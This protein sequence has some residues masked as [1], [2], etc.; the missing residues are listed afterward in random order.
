MSVAE[1]SLTDE[2]LRAG[3]ASSHRGRCD[4]AAA[5]ARRHPVPDGRQAV[6][7]GPLD[8]NSIL[9]G[10]ETMIRREIGDGVD[11][12][13]CLAADL[14]AA[15]AD[16]AQ[17]EQV[18]LNLSANARDAMPEGG[19]LTIET[20]NAEV[21]EKSAFWHERVAPGQYVML[22][23]SDTG[24][25]MDATT[26]SRLFEPFFPAKTP[27]EGASL[28]LCIVHG[29][30]SRNGGHIWLYSEPGHGTILRIY[31]PRADGRVGSP[32]SPDEPVVLLRGT[33]T[34]LLAEDEPSIRAEVLEALA[35]QGY[36]ILEACDGDQALHAASGHCGAIDL[37]VTDMIM[38]RVGGPEV[39]ERLGAARPGIKVLFM[40]GYPEHAAVRSGAL[41]PGTNYLQKPFTAEALIGRVREVLD[42]VRR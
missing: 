37:L 36:V 17:M 19:E 12:R 18:L 5:P 39:A 31:L 32:Q 3:D 6:R 24:A 7:P 16:T 41:P 11:L 40:S 26:R 29:I 20:G 22:T 10:M 28:G 34:I 8:L 13:M 4:H 38:P 1:S 33:E 23:I 35:G 25:G 21:D 27:G 2:R 30:V 9:K 15:R 14:W 42:G